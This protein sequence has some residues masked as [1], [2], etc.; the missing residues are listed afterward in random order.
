MSHSPAI[1]DRVVTVTADGFVVAVSCDDNLLEA[2]LV[3]LQR[4]LLTLD[5]DLA[6][7]TIESGAEVAADH[8]EAELVRRSAARN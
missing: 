4:F 3:G 5:T 1:P 8:R 6:L 2:V 7:M